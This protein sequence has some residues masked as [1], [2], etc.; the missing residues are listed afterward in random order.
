MMPDTKKVE[1]LMRDIQAIDK[2][3]TALVDYEVGKI[4]AE[5][6]FEA[7]KEGHARVYLAQYS[8]YLRGLNVNLKK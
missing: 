6:A 8:D 7:V 2:V 4:T 3:V 1:D 5:T